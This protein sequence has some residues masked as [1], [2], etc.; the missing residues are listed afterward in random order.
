MGFTRSG[1]RLQFVNCKITIE[2]VD[3]PS[4]SMVIFHSYVQ[5]PEGINSPT[6]ASFFFVPEFGANHQAVRHHRSEPV[7]ILSELGPV[8]VL[9]QTGV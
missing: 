4:D 1:K 3:L 8:L 7:C 5:L 9:C 6:C 2:I